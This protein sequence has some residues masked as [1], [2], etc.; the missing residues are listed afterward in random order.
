VT[1]VIDRVSAVTTRVRAAMPAVVAAGVP[2]AVT[3]GVLAVD[4][5]LRMVAL[6]SF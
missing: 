6:A 4:W 1:G 3:A 5:V 2:P